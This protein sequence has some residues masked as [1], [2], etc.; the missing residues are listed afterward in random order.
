MDWNLEALY[1][2]FGEDFQ[3]DEKRLETALDQALEDDFSD[4]SAAAW[5]TRLTTLKELA[6]LRIRLGAYANLRNS[7]ESDHAQAVKA[8]DR[9]NA[10]QPKMVAYNVR[11]QRALA[12]TD[13]DLLLADREAL[14]PYAFFLQEQK[15]KSAH[16][17]SDAEEQLFSELTQTG[18]QAFSQLKE[19][20]T[21]KH[22]VGIEL[23]G[24]TQTLPL[25]AIRNLAYHKDPAVRKNAYH[26]ELNSYQDIEDSVAASLNAIK[27]E[28]ITL[29]KK[30][31]FES[32]LANTLDQSRMDPAI[33]DS[34][35]TA[36][37][38]AKPVFQK[39]L[40]HKAKLL[41]HQDGLPFYDLFAPVGEVD[42]TY[43]F[44]DAADYVID[45]FHAY[46]DALGD[47]AQRAVDE[48]WIDVY[49]KKGKRGGAFCSNLHPIGQSRFMLNFT[50][51]YS[52]LTTLAHELGHGWHGHV[53]ADEPLLNSS[54]PMPL[55]ETASTF[56]ELLVN[57][58][59]MKD[60]DDKT[61]AAI[62]ENSISG[63]TQTC[64][65]IRSRFLFEDAVFAR[66]KDGSLS[67]DEI[68]ELMLDAQ[69]QAYGDGL[70]PAVLHPYMWINKPHYFMPGL[71]YY[72]FP[73]AFGNL[74]AVGLGRL[75]EEDPQ[76][77][78]EKYDRML[79]L[80]GRA[81]VADVAKS[82]GIDL[83]KPDFFHAS[84]AQ[85][86]KEI[87]EWIALTEKR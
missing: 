23:D 62:L 58:A 25:P 82:L 84:L 80:T 50:G 13:I 17:L 44:G 54:Y 57:T 79:A 63:V 21:A 9:V 34:L 30:R 5:E 6:A 3:N 67:V 4:K 65:D 38:E 47:Y 48:Q 66:R 83:T 70:D 60:A 69:K 45:K 53:L 46:S 76:G 75:Y 16:L 74:F 87:D 28:A 64:I 35:W 14:R 40:R 11:I 59:A 36:I 31:G 19:L 1:P 37:D 22:M 29:A 61:R 42:L 33:L 55:A 56:C 26:A 7:I 18:S 52:N 2:D 27:G 39:Y 10:L 20:L 24:K 77:F 15:K 81:D 86:E 85:V 78:P 71:D 32:P 51:S 49:P 73:Y 72:N 68:K 43:T 41:G 8:K 12:D